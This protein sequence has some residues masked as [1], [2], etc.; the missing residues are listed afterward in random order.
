V[1]YDLGSARTRARDRAPHA[2]GFFTCQKKKGGA[3]KA[4]Q[5]NAK[6]WLKRC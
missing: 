1:S 6:A 4:Q 2:Y 5:S 3:K